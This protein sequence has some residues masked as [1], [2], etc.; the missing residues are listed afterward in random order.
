VDVGNSAWILLIQSSETESIKKCLRHI[1]TPCP[2]N[3]EGVVSCAALLHNGHMNIL[4][5]IFADHYE[6]MIYTLHPRDAVIEN[7]E[8]MIHCGD[9]SYGGAM[10]GCPKCGKLKCLYDQ[11]DCNHKCQNV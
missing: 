5:E 10:Y 3:H 7:V 2:L 8:K 4:Q 9:S 1:N 6:E 11:K